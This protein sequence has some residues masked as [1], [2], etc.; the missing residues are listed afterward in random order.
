MSGL[1]RPLDI[2]Y[3]LFLSFPVTVITIQRIENLNI[4]KKQ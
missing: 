1:P 2:F 3:Y 4:R